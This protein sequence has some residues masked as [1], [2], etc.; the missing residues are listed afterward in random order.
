[1]A[2]GSAENEENVQCYKLNTTPASK[3]TSQNADNVGLA[4]KLIQDERSANSKIK[5]YLNLS[6]PTHKKQ[7]VLNL[8]EMKLRKMTSKIL[9]ILESGRQERNGE[10]LWAIKQEN[11]PL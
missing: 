10:K 6:L 4:R 1:M 9:E 7:T 3:K 2:K 11:L 8:L 5:E